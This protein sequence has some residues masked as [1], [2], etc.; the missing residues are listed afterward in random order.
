ILA[1]GRFAKILGDGMRHHKDDGRP[2]N[3]RSTLIIYG[4][5]YISL[6]TVLLS[7][8]SRMGA[9]VALAGTAVAVAVM[10]R[11]RRS[12]IAL[13]ALLPAI[14]V[15]LF[16]YGPTLFERVGD[17]QANALVRGDF[18]RQVWELIM[19]RPLTGFGGGSFELAYPLVHAAPV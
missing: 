17:V 1:V 10:L 15:A 13:L 12:A 2:A 9:F 7:T 14:V 5:A 4:M 19:L 8:A 11:G 3:H 16:L 6:L 18:Y